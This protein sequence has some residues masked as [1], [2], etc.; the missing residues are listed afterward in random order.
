MPPDPSSV[1]RL[2]TQNIAATKKMLWLY[3]FTD[4]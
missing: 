2:P 3:D 4:K 1:A